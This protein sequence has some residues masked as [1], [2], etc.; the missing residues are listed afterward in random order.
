MTH[1]EYVVSP[2]E[3][4]LELLNE[5]THIVISTME[6]QQMLDALGERLLALFGADVCHIVLWDELHQ[7]PIP[8]SVTGVESQKYPHLYTEPGQESF[9]RTILAA[10]QVLPIIDLDNSPFQEVAMRQSCPP[11][12]SLLGLPLIAGEEKLGAILL[13]YFRPDPVFT[14]EEILWAEQTARQLSLAIARI[15]LLETEKEQRILAETLHEGNQVLSVTMDPETLLDRLLELIQRIIPYDAAV[16]MTYKEGVAWVVRARGYEVFGAEIAAIVAQTRFVVA[17]TPNLQYMM[18][19]GRPFLVSDTATDPHW[20]YVDPLTYIKSWIGV[21]VIAHDTLLGFVSLDNTTPGFYQQHHVPRLVAFVAQAALSLSNAHLWRETRRQVQELTALH[22]VAQVSATV[23]GEDDLLTQ[24]TNILGDSLYPDNFGFL[25]YDTEKQL[26]YP[27][28]AYRP[29]RLLED[30]PFIVP[31]NG[32]TGQVFA[33]GRPLRLDD[34]SQYPFYVQVDVQ[35]RSEVCVPLTVNGHTIGVINAESSHLHAFT[36]A[37]ERVLLTLAGQIASTIERLRLFAAEARRR[38]EAETLHQAIAAVSSTL[39]L[40]EVLNA[41]LHQLSRV[42]P[43]DSA[44]ILLIQDEWVQIVAGR[45]FPDELMSELVGQ[46]YSAREDLVRQIV[47]SRRPICLHDAQTDPRFQNWGGVTHI[48]GWIGSPLVV[49][50]RVIGLLTIDNCQI[51]AYTPADAQLALVFAYQAATAIEHARLYQ[52]TQ[53]AQQKTE[54]QATNL[55]TLA[56][57]LSILN[58]NPDVQTAFPLVAETI[59][60]FTHADRISIFQLDQRNPQTGQIIMSLGQGQSLGTHQRIKIAHTAAAT[61]ILQGH[62]HLTPDL[63]AER[64]YLIEDLLYQYG[65]RAR[66]SLPL[67]VPD[68][69][70]GSLNLFWCS[71]SGYNLEGISLLEQISHALALA[72]E[73]TYLLEEIR[74]RATELET[75]IELSARLRQATCLEDMLPVI[76]DTVRQIT[77]IVFVAIL[78][79]DPAS[80]DLVVRCEYPPEFNRLGRHLPPGQGVSGHVFQS[81][82]MVVTADLATDPRTHINPDEQSHLSQI[83]GS[84]TLPLR[85]QERVIGVLHLTLPKLYDVQDANVR[86]LVALAELAGSALDRALVME[87]L[88]QRV[89]ART[90]DLAAANEQLKELDRLKSKFVSDV[91]HELRTPVTNLRLYMDLLERSS[92]ERWSHYMAVLQQQTDRLSNLIQDILNLS[93]LEMGGGRVELSPVDLNEVTQ[94][95]VEVY[96]PRIESAELDLITELQPDLPLVLGERNQLAQVVTN[97]LGNAIRYTLAG[98]IRVATFVDLRR[99]RVCLEVS[100]TGI[101]IHPEEHAYIFDRFYRGRLTGQSNIPGTGLGLA[102]V[103]EIVS[104]HRGEIEVQSAQNEGATFRVWLWLANPSQG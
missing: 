52:A 66:I 27:H 38:H 50:G 73:R 7:V 12:S 42:I 68:K 95:V 13:F 99:Q 56:H 101:G 9:T 32:V 97:L 25:I 2:R 20:Q 29:T 5:I 30:V 88:E 76:T 17:E 54:L 84:I 45:G 6:F 21:P 14:A 86:L 8:T 85:T 16:Y 90:H 70:Y 78:L 33:T 102:I 71:L 104:L 23:L 81:G 79:H 1:L 65:F 74:R 35:S 62:L 58:A 19:T 67:A 48:H 89:V 100:D 69:T 53:V 22:T 49:R 55:E 83:G 15:R 24:V 59:Q 64:Q 11:H 40:N 72:M 46:Q 80:G 43:Y 26:L 18:D 103:K 91:S 31:G 51:G 41:I 94:M 92:P 10:E 75:L 47:E 39:N 77:E 96:E 82:K 87:T 57:I 63:T 98:T 44:A 36:A 61:N 60:Q 34:V 93:R 37:D 28:R 3:R 4:Y